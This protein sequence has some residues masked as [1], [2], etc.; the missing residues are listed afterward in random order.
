MCRYQ[1]KS[2]RVTTARVKDNLIAGLGRT[3]A[4]MGKMRAET[5]AGKEMSVASTGAA[6]AAVEG[7]A[8]FRHPSF[9]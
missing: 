3:A 6:A 5:D 7:F 1:D 9:S 4:E 2:G 8:A